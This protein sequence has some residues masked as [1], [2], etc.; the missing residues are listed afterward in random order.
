MDL[1]SWQRT[2]AQ[3]SWPAA[4][5]SKKTRIFGFAVICALAA[6]TTRR[7]PEIFASNEHLAQKLGITV[8]AVREMRADA[9]A[10]GIL[11]RTDKVQWTRLNRKPITV[12]TVGWP[13][14]FI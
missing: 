4:Y 1:I 13:E 12:F 6:D 11:V 8:R 5:A 2:W 10:V 7:E 14:A 9:L 3:A